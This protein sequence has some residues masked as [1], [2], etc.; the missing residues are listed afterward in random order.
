MPGGTC[1][2]LGISAPSRLRVQTFLAA[3]STPDGMAIPPART[4]RAFGIHDVKE[5]AMPGK[6]PAV[7][8]R[9]NL[10]VAAGFVKAKRS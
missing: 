10:G 7:A 6:C 8:H 2:R 1:V 5:P 3:T 9:W 4:G